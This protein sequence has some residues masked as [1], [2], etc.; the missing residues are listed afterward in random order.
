MHVALFSSESC[1]VND[2]MG[3]TMSTSINPSQGKPGWPASGSSGALRNLF[4]DEDRA[5]VERQSATFEQLLAGF[6]WKPI[7][8]PEESADSQASGEEVTG[9]DS[10]EKPQSSEKKEDAPTDESEA[11]AAI[12]DEVLLQTEVVTTLQDTQRVE[13]AVKLDDPLVEDNQ[14]EEVAEVIEEVGQG[15]IAT[16]AVIA[17]SDVKPIEVKKQISTEAG[18]KK[19]QVDHQGNKHQERRRKD[20]VGVKSEV[21]VREASVVTPAQQQAKAE[22]K[23]EVVSE[24]RESIAVG[25]NQN[26]EETRTN[27]RSRKERLAEN[28]EN[29]QGDYGQQGAPDPISDSSG[30]AR[31]DISIKPPEQPLE[32]RGPELAS[33]TP[34]VIAAPAPAAPVATASPSDIRGTERSQAVGG[35][36]GNNSGSQ[37]LDSRS[38]QANRSEDPKQSADAKKAE[39]KS[40]VDQ[41]QQIRLIQRV[42]RGFERIGDQGGNI[43][44]RLH[45]PELGSLAMTVRVEGKSLSAEIV[46]ETPQARQ[47]LVENLPQLRKQLADSGLT[48]ERFDV[49]VMD[50]QGGN[51]GQTFSGQTFSGQFSNQNSSETF[52]GW[53]QANG[54]RNDPSRFEGTRPLG[55]EYSMSMASTQGNL[56]NRSLDIRV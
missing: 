15:D 12:A 21:G 8:A 17:K 54:R 34:Q 49:R 24:Q 31:P 16:E 26:M 25:P 22:V 53:N 2:D 27:R 36:Q 40:A 14:G 33:G 50:Q 37:R 55:A 51:A 47:V 38:E 29:P 23:K 13:A 42:A 6:E 20:D 45:P 18:E 4:S 7:E 39:E 44:L 5:S 43:R 11:Q 56:S 3:D 9:I 10:S 52:R 46:T 41:R 1:C 32:V 19:V 30:E 48:I 35:V 28:A